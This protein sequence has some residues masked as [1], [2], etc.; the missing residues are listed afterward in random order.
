LFLMTIVMSVILLS[1]GACS[2]VNSLNKQ[3]DGLENI[4]AKYEPK[5][6][7]IEYGSKEYAEMI[8]GYNKEI[9]DWAEIFE[10]DRYKRDSDH[11]ILYDYANNPMI[12][13]EFNKEVE[14]RFYELN[15][16]MT[17]MVLATIP[18]KE[19]PEPTA[20]ENEVPVT[21]Q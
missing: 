20:S 5:F 1:F 21:G 16:R 2:K 13:E 7:S 14:K 17:N 15:N 6:R 4:I 9:T 19:R 12:N 8:I 11:K 10:N 18:Q 3:L